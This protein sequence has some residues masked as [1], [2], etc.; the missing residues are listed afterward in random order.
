MSD[1]AA[2]ASV[3]NDTVQA[4]AVL[5]LGAW[6]WARFVHGRVLHHRVIP[7]IE[8]R[9]RRFD[10]YCALIVNVTVTNQ[11]IGRLP[12]GGSESSITI[13]RLS[14]S[15]WVPGAATWVEEGR[16]VQVF[17]SHQLLEPGEDVS[18]EQLVILSEESDDGL[19]LAYRVTLAVSARSGLFRRSVD[20][21]MITTIVETSELSAAGTERGE[22]SGG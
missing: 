10:E 15:R 11:G 6:T 4:V 14:S 13:G 19:A 1:L 17:Q 5:I 9:W 22:R 12:L 8:A 3:A 21:W 2:I 18:D 7:H 16:S 20:H